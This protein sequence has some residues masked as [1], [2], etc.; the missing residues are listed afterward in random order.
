MNTLRNRR[1][2]LVDDTPSIHEDFR[3]ILTPLVDE[4]PD[5]DLMEAALFG[6]EV[7]TSSV[8]P[9]EL[10]SA[11]QGQEGLQKVEQSVAC[12]KPYAL[13]FVDMRMPQGW[14]GA[15]TI[16]HLWQVDPNLQVVVCT[17]YTDYSWDELLER[18]HG[19][20]RLVILKKP[21]DNIEVQQLANTLT[22]K[23]EMTERAN[24]QM[25]RLEELVEQRTLAL[26]QTSLALQHEI[27]ERK[28]LEGQLV[29]SEKLAS[30][31]QLAAGVAHEI[32]NPIGF[33]SSNLGTLEGYFG[34]L[35][36]MLQAYQNAEEGV[37][38]PELR[39][40]LKDLRE[41]VELDFL[42][43]DIPLLIKESKEGI[44]RVGQIV[45]DLKNFSRV[46]S[47]QEWQWSNLQ[48]GIESTLNIVANELKYKADVVKDYAALPEIEC[49]ASQINQVIMN[50]VVN[51]A[52]AMGPERGT[53]TLRGGSLGER[54]WLEVADTGS[55]MAPETVQKIFDPFFT[56][57]PIGQG[58]G[59]GLSLSY[60]IV[61]KHAGQ[62]TVRSEVG[63][64]TTFRIE[65]PIRQN[66]AA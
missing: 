45:K 59:L 14:D 27:D 10:D 44:G 55:G 15:E 49:L 46:D 60:G 66:K 1:I 53:I 65:L 11:Y 6:Q 64:G 8:L 50:L 47:N 25:H 58:T 5:L 29:Q 12:G 52:Q 54:I 41:R 7:K 37:A 30:L 62:I 32:N 9:F 34:K 17:A 24:L 56:T 51:A 19:H 38:A 48:Q 3:K 2:L 63:V 42:E 40:R 61:Q 57:K 22:N 4:S 33:I 18:L 20:D 26:K 16:E 43:E 28:Q 13:A 31:G 23:W 36:E 39:A 21:F 35:L